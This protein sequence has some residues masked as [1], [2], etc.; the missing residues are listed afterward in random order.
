M[1]L[2]EILEERFIIPDLKSLTKNEAVTELVESLSKIGCIDKKEE[3][4]KAIFDREALGSTGIGNNIAIPHA[5]IKGVDKATVIYARS[6]RGVE[7]DSLDQKP[8]NHIFLLLAPAK[9]STG[10]HLKALARISRLFKNSSFRDQ[11]L[12]GLNSKDIYKIIKV[13]DAKYD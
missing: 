12:N 8:V 1:K 13:E 5:R 10:S 2:T 3:L 4:I 11:L 9:D 6:L 7:F